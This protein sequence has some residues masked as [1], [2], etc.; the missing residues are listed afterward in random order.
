MLPL[1]EI[2]SRRVHSTSTRDSKVLIKLLLALLVVIHT[3]LL[4][5][6]LPNAIQL[7]NI[8]HA[9]ASIASSRRYG[10]T[11]CPR[12]DAKHSLVVQLQTADRL[13]RA[14]LEIGGADRDRTCDLCLA[15]APLSQLSYSPIERNGGPG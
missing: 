14:G 10:Q 13:N 9:L 1:V 2:T 11:Y 7:S 4:D 6:Y 3:N 12:F 15:K 8:D 5:L